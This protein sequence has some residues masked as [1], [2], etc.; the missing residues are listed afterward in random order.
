MKRLKDLDNFESTEETTASH[1]EVM[2][3]PL[4]KF[5]QS[6]AESIDK[7]ETVTVAGPEQVEE[8]DEQTKLPKKTE[9]RFE[10]SGN[11][12]KVAKIQKNLIDLAQ[13]LAEMSDQIVALKLNSPNMNPDDLTIINNLKYKID[14]MVSAL[15]KEKK[16][17]RV[18]G[19][20]DNSKRMQ[21]NLEHL[22]KDFLKGRGL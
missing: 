5:L 14:N 3:G 9:F 12:K 4:V 6:M 18:T 10:I 19:M 15:R 11:L 21:R 17:G 20:I 16:N 2:G 22:K 1:S 13:L 8:I 7:L